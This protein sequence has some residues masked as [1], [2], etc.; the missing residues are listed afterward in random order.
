MSLYVPCTYT[1]AISPARAHRA[2]PTAHYK[3]SD[4]VTQLTDRPGGNGLTAGP[5]SYSIGRNTAVLRHYEGPGSTRGSRVPGEDSLHTWS[6]M[7]T[8]YSQQALRTTN[9]ICTLLYSLRFVEY[10]L[11]R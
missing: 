2:L 11:T 7:Y 10:L 8:R 3:T 4:G 9:T 6:S 1:C 5:T